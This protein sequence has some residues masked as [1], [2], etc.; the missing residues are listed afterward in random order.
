MQIYDRL[1]LA[2]LSLEFRDGRA[3]AGFREG[4]EKIR[5][6]KRYEEG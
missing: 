1:P 3:T 4:G 2:E 5:A 6:K